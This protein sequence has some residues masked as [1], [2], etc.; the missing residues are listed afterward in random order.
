MTAYHVYMVYDQLAGEPISIYHC[1]NDNVAILSFANASQGFQDKG[2]NLNLVSLYA[3]TCF[4]M[5]KP[6][7]GLA[8]IKD[9]SSGHHYHICT[10][11]ESRSRLQEVYDSLICSDK[12][13]MSNEEDGLPKENF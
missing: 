1:P 10:L 11:A 2:Y 8:F 6:D 9:V 4:D 12:D 5:F 7:T 3:L 13:V